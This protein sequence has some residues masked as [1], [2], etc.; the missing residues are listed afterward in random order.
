MIHKMTGLSAETYGLKEKG[1]IAAG[2]DA[3]LV[4]F[5]KEEIGD[6]ADFVNSNRLSDGIKIVIVGGKIA[7]QD[8]ILTEE[9]PGKWIGAG[10]RT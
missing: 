4:L 3:D 1:R 6:A 10:G 8:G 2:Y 7:Y 9:C 5:N